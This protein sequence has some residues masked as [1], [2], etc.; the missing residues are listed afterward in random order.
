MV[1]HL[2]VQLFIAL[3]YRQRASVQGGVSEIKVFFLL[4]FSQYSTL[5]GEIIAMKLCNTAIFVLST[6]T[7]VH[8]LK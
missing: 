1:P 5:G 7:T 4:L 8:P 6:E 3:L 2:S